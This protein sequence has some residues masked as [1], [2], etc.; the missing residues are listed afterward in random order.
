MLSLSRGK[1]VSSRYGQTKLPHC[2]LCFVSLSH[3]FPSVPNDRFV[4]YLYTHTFIFF[5]YMTGRGLL[6]CLGY[7]GAVESWWTSRNR[8]RKVEREKEWV[9]TQT[10]FNSDQILCFIDTR[11]IGNKWARPRCFWNVYTSVLHGA[12]ATTAACSGG[13]S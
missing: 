13:G 7:Y 1:Y 10:C 8:K 5:C 9:D 3:S 4:L 2:L 11:I 6:S 12:A